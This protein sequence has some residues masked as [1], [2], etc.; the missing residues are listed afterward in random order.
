[1][2]G[3]LFVVLAVALAVPANRL[4]SSHW[5]KLHRAL[6]SHSL[7]FNL[8]LHQK[9]KTG[10][11]EHLA[12]ISNPSHAEFGRWM[13]VKQ[14]NSYLAPAKSARK[15]LSAALAKRGFRVAD[16]GD[17]FVVAASVATVERELR[18]RVHHL[19]Q[20]AGQRT[21]VKADDYT[22]PA[23]MSGM[24]EL[25]TGL[26]ELPLPRRKHRTRSLRQGVQPDQEAIIPQTL[27][28]QYNIS[29]SSLSPSTT[30][31][32]AEFQDDQAYLS[33]DMTQF[34]QLTNEPSYAIQNVGPFS[35]SDGEST[36]DIQYAPAVARGAQATF[37]VEKDWMHSFAAKIA[38]F[39]SPPS[40]ISMSW[41]WPSNL[42]CL[43]ER[44]PGRCLFNKLYIDRVNTE[45]AKVTARG[46]SL[47]AASGDQGAPGDGFAQNGGGVSDIFP[48]GS[49]YVTCVG[50]TMFGPPASSSG[51]SLL[52]QSSGPV[53]APACQ[54]MPCAG[55]QP[56]ESFPLQ[57]SV[58]MAPNALITSGGGFADYSPQPSWQSS[59][60]AGYFA[61]NPFTPPASMVQKNNRAFPDIAANGHFYLIVLG[62]QLM[63]VDGTSASSPVAAGIVARA[64]DARKKAGKATLGFLNQLIYQA[65]ASVFGDITQGNNN[66]SETG[67][68]GQ[69]WYGYQ[70]T[71]GWDA[72]T[73][74]GTLNA[75]AFVA[76]ALTLP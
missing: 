8:C 45:F 14:I 49:P 41:G 31:A 62:G 19:R 38:R 3:L 47:L 25:I 51:N 28:L 74:R 53:N 68:F 15:A 52:R 76:Y 70:A 5:T 50:A 67:S 46:V 20:K 72:T 71:P 18:T 30:I 42:M 11:L 26:T 10:F 1:M 63:Q 35:G 75:A 66:S 22:L 69:G 6:P 54:Q 58:C 36:L 60:V 23:Y 4:P 44:G 61:Q 29:S 55:N 16:H 37:W 40:V 13:S 7:E 24:V 56:G 9:N 59:A 32:V 64:N 34:Y 33:S 2:A 12:R 73:G 17:H 48:G 43:F 57:E 39:P 21:I 27:R 65:P